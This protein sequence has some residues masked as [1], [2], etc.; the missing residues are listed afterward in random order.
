MNTRIL[1]AF[2][3]LS[4]FRFAEAAQFYPSGNAEIDAVRK[5]VIVSP[6]TSENYR[7]RT[8][9]LFMWLGALQQQAADTR[10]FFE[11]DR[12]YYRLEP[13]VNRLQD[14]QQSPAL[15]QM[16]DFVDRAYKAMG[17]I[18]SSLVEKG[19]I[20]KPFEGDPANAPRG[21]DMEADWPMFQRNEHNTGYT[22]APGPATGRQAWRFPVGLG[23]YS[24][25]V[26]EDGRVYI[27]SP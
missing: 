3:V 6:T 25:P 9:L 14:G 23:W 2:L 13:Q 1:L 15:T 5:A 17:E 21:G 20:F 26:V 10:P 12:E 16:C 24:R 7:E 8:L 18:Q 22:P 11:L 27:A 4:W 19:P